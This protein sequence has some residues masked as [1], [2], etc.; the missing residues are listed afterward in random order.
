MALA[1]YVSTEFRTPNRR[2]GLI[3]RFIVMHYTASRNHRSAIRVLTDPNTSV[4]AH[5]VVSL[6]GEVFKLADLHDVT[7]HAGPSEY[8]GFEGLNQYSIGIEIVNLGW[9]ERDAEGLIRDSYGNEVDPGEFPYGFEE[10]PHPRVGSGTYLWPR[11]TDHQLK[12]VERLTRD[13]IA[14][15]PNLLAIVSHEEIDTRGW[16]TDPGPAFPMRRFRD[17]LP[18]RVN[19]VRVTASSL[20]VRAN[21]SLDSAKVSFSPLRRGAVAEVQDSSGEWLKVRV[22][23]GTGWVHGA[24][25]ESM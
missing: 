4:S 18:K 6:G 20:N 12:A 1:N 2:G 3:P 14:T 8:M 5:F 23:E 15:F 25:T 22:A 7:W 17:L 13:L 10:A 24:Y 11:Y 16:K 21:P 19:A 9:C